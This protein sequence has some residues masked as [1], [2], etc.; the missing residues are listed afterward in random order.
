MTVK[1]NN[2]EPTGAY[3]AG[4]DETASP[5]IPSSKTNGEAKWWISII[6]SNLETAKAIA[7][8]NED[9]TSERPLSTIDET[10]LDAPRRKSVRGALALRIAAELYSA[11][12]DSLAPIIQYEKDAVMLRRHVL[13]DRRQA[14]AR[15]TRYNAQHGWTKR[16]RTQGSWDEVP[17]PLSTKG[18]SSL[19]MPV[20]VSDKESLAPFFAH[21]RNGGALQPIADATNSSKPGHEPYYNV[22]FI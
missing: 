14:I 19:P 12:P 22:E 13:E 18:P 3:E 15:A 6:R 2:F 10:V 9:S 20:E 4:E 8:A 21:L 11:P 7:S 1:L 16:I 17:D 5:N